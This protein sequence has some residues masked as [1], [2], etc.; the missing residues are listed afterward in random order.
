MATSQFTI[1]RSND[2]GAPFLYGTTGSVISILDACLVNGFGSLGGSG[3]T[4][5]FPNTSSANG[6]HSASVGCY[7]QPSGSGLYLF[8]NDNR[9][10]GLSLGKEAW[11]TGWEVLNDL[12]SS[13][14][15]SV[16]S[17]SN[18]FPTGS[19]LLTSG[20]VVIRKSS[21]NDSS[22]LRQWVVIADSSSFYLLIATGDTANMYYGFGFGDI[23]SYKTTTDQYR[24]IIMGRTAENSATAATD[25][26]DLFSSMGAATIGNYM[27]RNYTG[28][29]TSAIMS[30]H[31]DGV[32]GSTTGSNGSI[33]FPN[34]VDSALY[35]SPIWVCETSSLVR[36]QLRG[37]YHVLHSQAN[38]VDGQLFSGSADYAGKTFQV[39]KTTP[40]TGI[41]AFETSNTVL[42]N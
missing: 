13:V 16:G 30:K 1:Y 37:M 10:N 18:S 7:Q 29:I 21:T 28:L 27:A 8:I 33:P 20:H 25:G 34:T 14:S 42:T 3:W 31:G 12:S 24:C 11:A 35:V 15:S 5:P 22:S 39:F 32:K 2:A 36:G 6:V 38:F 40:S 4:K 41:Y 19:Q 26:F 23:Y 17:G 9:P